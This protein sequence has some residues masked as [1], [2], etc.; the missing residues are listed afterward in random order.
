MVQIYPMKNSELKVK[1]H[2]SAVLNTWNQPSISLA[3]SGLGTSSEALH[4][5]VT[6]IVPGVS[7][8]RLF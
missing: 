2:I 5:P 1:D 3:C 4:H 8:P 6:P 7:T